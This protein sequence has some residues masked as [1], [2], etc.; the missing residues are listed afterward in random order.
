M[1][2]FYQFIFLCYRLSFTLH[3]KH[4]VWKRSLCIFNYNWNYFLLC[5]GSFVFFFF[6]DSHCE[7]DQENIFGLFDMKIL[8]KSLL[9]RTRQRRRNREET[10]FSL[11]SV[12]L[13]FINVIFVFPH[14]YEI[15]ELWIKHLVIIN[16]PRINDNNLSFIYGF[17]HTSLLPQLCS[18]LTR[19]A[20][21]LWVKLFEHY[22]HVYLDS[23][24]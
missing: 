13:T 23:S 7:R 2:C 15:Y 3:N 18:F 10:H 6:F 4:A 17:H 20:L 12:N 21:T 8:S 1:N 14:Y 22:Y 19:S 24:S 11:L 9:K 5:F 16:F